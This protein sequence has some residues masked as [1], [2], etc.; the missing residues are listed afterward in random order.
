LGKRI[1][2]PCWDSKHGSSVQ[3]VAWYY[4]VCAIVSASWIN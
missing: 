3:L 4:S 1:S 2:W